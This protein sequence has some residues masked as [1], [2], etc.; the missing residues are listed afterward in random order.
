LKHKKK[1]WSSVYI[2]LRKGIDY[3]ILSFYWNE[4][5]H[6]VKKE[7]IILFTLAIIEIYGKMVNMSISSDYL[8]LKS[9]FALD[10][11]TK[12]QRSVS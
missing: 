2:Y 6:L 8:G 3:F 12:K 10:Y 4:I 5:K 11:I 1:K 9:L 7:R